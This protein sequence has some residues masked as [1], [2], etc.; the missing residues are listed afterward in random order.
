VQPEQ[1]RWTPL[2]LSQA[3]LSRIR[4]VEKRVVLLQD[5]GHY[6]LEQ[7]GLVQMENSI[8]AFLQS[9]LLR[10]DHIRV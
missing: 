4:S 7:P 9:L 5:A 10:P 3:F 2:A 8:V 1:D 6:P